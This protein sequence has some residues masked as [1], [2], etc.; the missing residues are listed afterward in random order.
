MSYNPYLT[1]E[2][3]FVAVKCCLRY[4]DEILV[5]SEAR[6]GKPFWRE[7][8]GGKIS[9]DDRDISPLL[10]LA[11]EI[12]EELGL[13]I[14]LTEDNTR[15]FSVEKSY[16]ETTFA[17]L[18]VPFVFLCYI[19]DLSEKP[20]VVLSHEHTSYDWIHESEIE[21]FSDWRR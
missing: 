13:T 17:P 4:E 1:E 8:P 7:L 14:T 11:R 5:V 16:E 20:R 2:I 19:H 9:K 6:P 18:P 10:S 15:L 3:F 12:E 21:S